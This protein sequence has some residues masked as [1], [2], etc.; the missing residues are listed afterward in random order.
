MGITQFNINTDG[1]GVPTSVALEVEVIIEV[2]N[3]RRKP[4]EATVKAVDARVHS[5]D[6][7]AFDAIGEAVYIGDAVLQNE[8]KIAA[9]SIVDI[10]FTAG[11]T[12][13]S[14]TNPTLVSRLASD[15]NA[16][17]GS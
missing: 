3:P 6:K 1:L 9:E 8:V 10:K 15:C 13:E 14:S 7:G 5:L 17:G 2:D 12:P 4:I 11:T 16:L